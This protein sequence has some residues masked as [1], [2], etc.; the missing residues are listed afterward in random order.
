MERNNFEENKLYKPANVG[1]FITGG[2]GNKIEYYLH[3]KCFKILLMRSLKTMK[4][5][6]Y[7]LFIE[8]IFK[9]YNDY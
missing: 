5:A 4:Y 1:G 3:P 9:F 7:Y 8:D 2:R 6:E